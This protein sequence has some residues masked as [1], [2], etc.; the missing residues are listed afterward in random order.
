MIVVKAKGGKVVKT[1]NL[2]ASK[3]SYVAKLKAGKYKFAVV[4]VN[5]LGAGT[6]SAL[7][8]AV[9]AR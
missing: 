6:Q 9:T 8:K 5:S 7:S 1:V 2:A 4:A 3:T